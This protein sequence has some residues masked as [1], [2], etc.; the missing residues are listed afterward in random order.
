MTKWEKFAKE[1]G[2]KKVGPD[3]PSPSQAS[4]PSP[5]PPSKLPKP[6]KYQ[7]Y[8]HTFCLGTNTRLVN[9]LWE[10]CEHACLGTRNYLAKR[11]SPR[12]PRMNGATSDER[13]CCETP[14]RGLTVIVSVETPH[15][16]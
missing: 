16:R 2:I 4:L 15:D 3:I 5:C 11:S 7:A 13:T 10:V 8:N 12:L 9:S 14:S 6:F 1:K